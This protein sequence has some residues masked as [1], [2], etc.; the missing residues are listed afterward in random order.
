MPAKKRLP[1]PAGGKFT[2]PCI[3]HV[4]EEA[5]QNAVLR[6]LVPALWHFAVVVAIHHQGASVVTGDDFYERHLCGGGGGADAKEVSEGATCH[7]N[8]SLS[9]SP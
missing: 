4:S 2:Q 3:R 1:D 8:I 9:L 5:T 6:R 7:V